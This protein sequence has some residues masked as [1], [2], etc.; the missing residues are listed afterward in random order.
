MLM[1]IAAFTCCAIA[2]GAVFFMWK[3][4]RAAGTGSKAEKSKR[5]N[6]EINP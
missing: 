5:E 4:G 6:K 3:L 1:D 2:A